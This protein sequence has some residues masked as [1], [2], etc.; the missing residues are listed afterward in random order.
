MGKAV[1]A[2]A[3]TCWL[4]CEGTVCG[5]NDSP[6]DCCSVNYYDQFCNA[7][8]GS[9]IPTGTTIPVGAPAGPALTL[10]A[11]L[12]DLQPINTCFER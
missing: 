2:A 1:R 10:S 12:G 7:S 6:S 4:E 5:A 9:V 11:L 8:Y 3:R